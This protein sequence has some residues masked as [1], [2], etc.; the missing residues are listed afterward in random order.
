MPY[1]FRKP[2]RLNRKKVLE[3]MFAGGARSYSFFP[4][5]V[6]YVPAQELEA[7][8]S[9][10]VSVSKRRFKRAVKRNRVKRQVREA[11]RLN[12]HLLLDVLPPGCPPLAVA[13]IYLA[14]EL[15]DSRALR[16]AVCRL[17]WPAWPTTWLPARCRHNPFLLPTPPY[18]T[19][20]PAGTAVLVG[21]AADSHLLLPTVPVAPAG[22]VVPLHAHLLAI[23]RGGHQEARPAEGAVPCRAPH[24]AVPPLGRVGLRPCAVR[25]AL[26]KRFIAV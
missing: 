1:T 13:F 22:A 24:P 10:L 19:F 3:R 23:C 14:D 17:P 15:C 18:E 20:L 26:F 4:L 6:V 25:R 16:P 5:R 7:P 11:Y 8:V 2:E 9:V 12:K 21:T